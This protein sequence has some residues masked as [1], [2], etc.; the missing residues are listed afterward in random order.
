VGRSEG[1]AIIAAN[2]GRQKQRDGLGRLVH[3]GSK[4][5]RV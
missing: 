5:R 1:N 4:L 2:V 3:V